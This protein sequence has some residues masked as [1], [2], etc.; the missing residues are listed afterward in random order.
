MTVEHHALCPAHALAEG[1]ARGFCIE[2]A[3]GRRA[4]MLVRSGCRYYAY[5]NSCPHTGV[6]L[7]WVPDR[8]L[9]VSGEFIQ[10]A[11]HGALFRIG[12]GFCVHGP[13]AGRSLQALPLFRDGDLLGIAL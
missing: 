12:D 2:T 3:G 9:D 6:N 13:C 5:V 4:V 8:F 11:T 7:D 1:E 10:C